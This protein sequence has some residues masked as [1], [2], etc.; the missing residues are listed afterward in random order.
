MTEQPN[1]LLEQRFR[2]YMAREVDGF[3]IMPPDRIEAFRT[4]FMAGASTVN[5]LYVDALNV[6]S[7]AAVAQ[8]TRNRPSHVT[9]RELMD[10]G[11]RIHRE[12][13]AF[14]KSRMGGK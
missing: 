4:A 12:L 2:Q 13:E 3:A 10:C 5:G 9:L 7:K 14:V 6:D 1:D 8:A 11:K